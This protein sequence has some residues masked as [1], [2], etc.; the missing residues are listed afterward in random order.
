[1]TEPAVD[2]L[3]TKARRRLDRVLPKDLEQ[4]MADGALLIDT[5]PASFREEEGELPGAR[6][7]ERIHLEWRL[8]PSSPHRIDGFDKDTRVI[9]VCNEGYS[10]SLAA[11]TL[12][13]LGLRRA[14]DLIGGYRAWSALQ[15]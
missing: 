5:R 2:R 3:L 7:I 9:V 15:T 13:Q 6:V 11:A 4:E 14:T 8:D 12:R 1:M 10:S